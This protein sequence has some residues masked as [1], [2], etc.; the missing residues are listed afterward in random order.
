MEVDDDSGVVIDLL[1][2][3]VHIA[4]STLIWIV[5]SIACGI[6]VQG[7]GVHLAAALFKVKQKADGFAKNKLL[8]KS[9]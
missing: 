4:T 8:K 9:N 6:Y 1:L 5:W 7:H 2:I 3:H